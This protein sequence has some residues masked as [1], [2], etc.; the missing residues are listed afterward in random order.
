MKS[1]TT[2]FGEV[3]LELSKVKWPTRDEVVKL[4]LTV[5]LVSAV[6][7]LFVGGLD[8]LFTKTLSALLTN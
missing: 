4:T 8:F 7:G 3:K 1:I 6:L 5:F 2:F